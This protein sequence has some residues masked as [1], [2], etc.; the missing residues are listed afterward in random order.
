MVL[1]VSGVCFGADVGHGRACANCLWSCYV[2]KIFNDDVS[3]HVDTHCHSKVTTGSCQFSLY[4]LY[5]RYTYKCST[6][7]IGLR[8]MLGIYFITSD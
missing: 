2:V 3:L 7:G 4:K 6:I 1:T 8:G 5:T